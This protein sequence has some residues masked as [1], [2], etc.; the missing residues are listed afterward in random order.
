M[1]PTHFSHLTWSFDLMR[2]LVTTSKSSFTVFKSSKRF[3]S[4]KVAI[5][6][7]LIFPLKVRGLPSVWS[8]LVDK[9]HFM[10]IVLPSILDNLISCCFCRNFNSLSENGDL[11]ENL[12]CD[13]SNATPLPLPLISWKKVVRKWEIMFKEIKDFSC[14]CE[15]KIGTLEKPHSQ[16]LGAEFQFPI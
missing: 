7:S 4:S 11:L 13:F 5:I 14:V 15:Q 3:Y 2:S 1:T 8:L 16:C 9:Q 6:Y 10:T 12:L